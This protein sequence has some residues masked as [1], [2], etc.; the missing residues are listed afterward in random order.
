MV[1]FDFDTKCYSC[2]LCVEYCPTNA[3]TFDAKLHPILDES[4]CIHCS[5]CEKVCMELNSPIN[6]KRMEISKSYVAKNKDMVI[7]GN[8]SSGGVFI[9]IANFVIQSQVMFVAA[10]MMMI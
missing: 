6:A 5:K 2:S 8:S 7:R 4:K 1:S 3:I 9:E 10:Y